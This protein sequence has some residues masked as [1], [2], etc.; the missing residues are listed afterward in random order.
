[1]N[2]TSGHTS[3][4]PFARYDP[5]L[6]S[7]RTSPDTCLLDLPMSSLTLPKSGGMRNGQLYEHPMLGPAINAHDCSFLPTPRAQNGET[8]N[9][10]IYARPLD[11]P[12][13]L[14]NA[15]A[16]LPTPVADHSRGLQQ[17]G[18]DYQSLPNA[19]IALTG[20]STP[21]PSD[22]GQT[23]LGDQHQHQLSLDPQVDHD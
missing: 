21:K 18:T 7:W 5:I 20:G 4:Q 15:L 22:D 10:N 6:R 2:A 17:K 19:V 16:L 11:Q 12:Q 23:L 3:T 14:E 13:N 9:M 8:R 1:M